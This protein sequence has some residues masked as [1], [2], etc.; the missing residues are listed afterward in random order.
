[1]KISE[2]KQRLRARGT[3][4]VADAV[5]Q[6]APRRASVAREDRPAARSAPRQGAR[7]PA[8]PPRPRWQ[9]G[10]RYQI[11]FG[12]VY[13]IMA[14]FLLLQTLALANAPHVKSRPGTLEFLLPVGF[15]L[16]GVWWLYRG[17]QAQRALRTKTG[18]APQSFL[19]SLGLMGRTAGTPA[20]ERSANS[21]ASTQVAPAPD[22]GARVTRIKPARPVKGES[23]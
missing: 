12:L 4:P 6:Q 18:A 14:P 13:C 15:F 16:F 22:S 1:M 23:R 8:T 10:P 11:I 17:L 19:A 3:V 9:P 2:R 20:T 7:T 21:T 5:Y